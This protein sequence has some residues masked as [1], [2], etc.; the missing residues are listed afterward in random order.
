VT[1]GN[2]A[3][4]S[5][6]IEYDRN[7]QSVWSIKHGGDSNGVATHR[8]KFEYPDESITCISGYYG[9]LN[10]SDRYNVVKS[11]S[12]YTSRGRYGPYGEETGTFFTSTT[13]Q[14]KVLGFHG[15]SSFHLDAIGVHMQHWLGN[16]KSYYSRASCFKLF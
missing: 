16:N 1:R 13:T 12:F 2:D 14:G 10:N 6:Q 11:L 8:I 4:T 7:G 15:R 5:I 9:P 3:I